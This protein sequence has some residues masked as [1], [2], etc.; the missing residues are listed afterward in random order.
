LAQLPSKPET[1]ILDNK[2]IY[3]VFSNEDGRQQQEIIVKNH[4]LFEEKASI[5]LGEVATT[6]PDEFQ[7][8]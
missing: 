8:G 4:L 7:K 6:L 3:F 2:K 1:L 5:S